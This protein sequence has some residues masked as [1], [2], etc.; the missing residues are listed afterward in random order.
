MLFYS[1]LYIATGVGDFWWPISA[2]AIL[3][4]VD[5]WQ[6]S[7]NPPSSDSLSDVITLLIILHYKCTGP[8][9]G[10]ISCIDVLDF[11]PKKKYP[12][13]LLHASVSDT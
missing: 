8:F 4:D 6:F 9:L 12:P 11:G 1:V 2:R 5:L 3:V 13:D 10:G 7:K